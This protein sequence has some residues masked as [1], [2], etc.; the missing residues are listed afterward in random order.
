[1]TSTALS[2]PSV[3]TQSVKLPE[4]ADR[5]SRMKLS[6]WGKN[7]ADRIAKMICQN[8][9]LYYEVMMGTGVPWQWI[10]AI[11][12]MEC[13]GD[14]GKHLAN[15]DPISAPT[16]HEP[17]GTPAGTWIECA[18]AAL[19]LKDYTTRKPLDWAD[20]GKWLWRAEEYNGWGYTLYHPETPSPYLWSGTDQYNHGKY[21]ADGKWDSLAVS[22]QV[23]V[24]AIWASLGMIPPPKAITPSEDNIELEIMQEPK[25]VSA[26]DLKNVFQWWRGLPHQVAAVE[27]LQGEISNEDL[28]EFARIWRSEPVPASPVYQVRFRM[29][30]GN[31][32]DLLLGKL[33]FILNSKTYNEITCTSSLPGRQYSGSWNRKGGLIPPSSMVKAKAGVGLT[34]KTEP[35]FMPNVTGVSGNFYPIAPF[36][37]STDG[38]TRGDF[39]FHFDAGVVGSLGCLIATTEKG[40]AAGQRELKRIAGL[41]IRSIELIVEYA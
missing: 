3:I 23:G 4:Y 11:H 37:I 18:V 2:I 38:S 6:A 28:A 16:V 31:S 41:G 17:A 7:E 5:L 27:Y 36:S 25:A 35:I 22:Q 8:Q 21:T 1:M 34:L 32:D 40:W 10:G 9:G 20:F 24:V 12:W 29:A 39:G 30:T 14:F 26:I 33:E 15:G 19:E 13:G